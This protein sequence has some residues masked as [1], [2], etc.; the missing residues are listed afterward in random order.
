MVVEQTGAAASE[1]AQEPP[2]C[3]L[4]CNGK[5]KILHVSLIRCTR[6]GVISDRCSLGEQKRVALL[7]SASAEQLRRLLAFFPA[8][9][10]KAEWPGTQGQK[11][12]NACEIIGGTLD[13]ERIR[14]FLMA[15]FAHC[16]QHVLLLQRPETALDPLV[17]FPSPDLLGTMSGGVSFYLSLVNYTVYLLDPMEETTVQVLWPIKVEVRDEVIIIRS[18]VL[19]R[20]PENF[21]HRPVLKSIRQLDEKKIAADLNALGFVSLDINQGVK[22]MWEGKYFDAPRAKY[23]K[24]NLT[25]TVDMDDGIGLRENAPEVF[26][27]LM[28][29]PLLNTDFRPDEKME[30]TVA[31]FQINATFGKLG[32]TNYTDDPGDTDA[33]IQAILEN[34]K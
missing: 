7:T 6:N 23:K 17:A 21:S 5:N 13:Y 31:R 16:R 14:L 20:D 9:K 18:L 2:I 32:F 10:L 33:V 1:T 22:K 11:K 29:K 28:S 3:I 4:G 25:T 8:P 26:D 27:D 19:E 34:N 15:N 24:S 12:A 30:S